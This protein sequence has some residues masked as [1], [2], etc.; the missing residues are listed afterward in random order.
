MK[1]RIIEKEFIRTLQL[2]EITLT[3]L[4]DKNVIFNI[5]PSNFIF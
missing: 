2:A 1:E 5:Y 4:I 3:S